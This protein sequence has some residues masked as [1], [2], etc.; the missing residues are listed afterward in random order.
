M[1]KIFVAALSLAAGLSASGLATAPA[2]AHGGYGHGA[3]G[4]GTYGHPGVRVHEP[5]R[6]FHHGFYKPYGYSPVHVYRSY[7]QGCYQIK[8]RALRTGSRYWW[9]RYHECRG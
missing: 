5:K 9:H 3:Y 6:H 8:E 7:G 2:S 4:H 1:Q